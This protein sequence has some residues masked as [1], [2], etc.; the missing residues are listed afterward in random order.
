MEFIYLARL[1]N[2]I[3]VKNQIQKEI[4]LKLLDKEK[5]DIDKIYRL[6]KEINCNE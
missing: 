6:W 3:Q 2:I 4:L 1:K 5:T